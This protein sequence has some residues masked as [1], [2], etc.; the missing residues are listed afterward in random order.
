MVAEMVKNSLILEFFEVFII[1]YS[2]ILGRNFPNLTK[3]ILNYHP[4]VKNQSIR[5]HSFIFAYR[6]EFVR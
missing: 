6:H 1:H 2:D 3:L 4:I 5:K